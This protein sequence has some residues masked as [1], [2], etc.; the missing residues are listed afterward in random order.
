MGLGIYAV[1]VL[2]Y[3]LV[4]A[5]QNINIWNVK[6]EWKK[7]LNGLIRWLML[8]FVVLA[9]AVASF[10]LLNLAEANGIMIANAEAIAPSVIIS[11]VVLGSAGMLVKII[12][13]L[14]TTLGLT[15]Q[16]L[17][18]LQEQYVKNAE[19]GDNNLVIS[20]EG[21]PQPSEDYVESLKKREQKWEQGDEIGGLGLVY[22]V[23]ITSY[24]AFRATV[25]GKGYDTDNAYG[26]QCYDG[27]ALLWQQLGM[28]LSTGGTGQ[29]RGC[30]TVE[31]ARNANAGTQ[32]ELI[33]DKKQIKRG[34]ALILNAGV[35]GHGTYADEDYNG[36]D[37]IRTMGQN[38]VNASANGSPFAVCSLS[39]ASFL[40]AFRYKG[41]KTAPA[42]QPTPPAP[43]PKGDGTVE[44]TYKKGDTFGQVILNLG[45]NTA[46]GLWG[47]NGDVAYYTEQLHQQGIYGNIPIGK[48]IKLTP[49][50]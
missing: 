42:P 7:F 15:E 9:T 18:S 34:D 35:Y 20:L 11:I 22:N 10:L 39:L 49:R 25:I 41:W 40:G 23:P 48:K 17:H 36:T 31:S 50:K 32:F 3:T 44:Y 46:N 8:G 33:T 19:N 1:F 47:A 29:C 5:Y 4:S 37:T 38:Q 16:Q 13:K 12:A 26:Y 45:L 27:L 6:W 30:W 21:L 14:S 43:T 2:V 28:F 24:D